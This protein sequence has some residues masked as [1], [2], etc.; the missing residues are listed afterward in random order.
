MRETEW[1]PHKGSYRRRTHLLLPVSRQILLAYPQGLSI[2]HDLPPL[3]GVIDKWSDKTLCLP[4]PFSVPAFVYPVLVSLIVYFSPLWSLSLSALF[5]FPH[6]SACLHAHPAPLPLPQALTPLPSPSKSLYTRSVAWHNYLGVHLG[7]GP[8]KVPPICTIFITHASRA[9]STT[10]P[11]QRCRACSSR[12]ERQ[13]SHSHD[14]G[15]SNPH[16][17]GRGE[18]ITTGPLHLTVD[19]WDWLTTGPPSRASCSVLPGRG[20]GPVHLLS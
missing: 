2:G 10:L 3:P 14:L 6:G 11:R 1:R 15:A 13:L 4:S 5:L 16:Y 7:I 18:G 9:C 12:S 20:A 19:A 8:P 17:P